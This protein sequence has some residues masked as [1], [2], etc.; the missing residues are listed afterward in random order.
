MSRLKDL[1]Q[2]CEKT[3]AFKHLNVVLGNNTMI[4][5]C[6]GSIENSSNF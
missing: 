2:D 3:S 6:L 5:L 1:A 4:C